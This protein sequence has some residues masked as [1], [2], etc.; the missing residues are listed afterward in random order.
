MLSY[1]SEPQSRS[2]IPRGL[3]K[4]EQLHTLA[5]DGALESDFGNREIR[6]RPPLSLGLR[7]T[8]FKHSRPRGILC[9]IEILSTIFRVTCFFR[10]S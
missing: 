10:R 7:G 8:I 2:R 6:G 1:L 3:L 9:Q 4:V 5:G